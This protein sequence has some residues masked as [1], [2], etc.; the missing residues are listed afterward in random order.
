MS[1]PGTALQAD[2]DI[3]DTILENDQE[4]TLT[5]VGEAMNAEDPTS[6]QSQRK[7]ETEERDED[8][9]DNLEKG[10]RTF[11]QPAE[12]PTDRLGNSASPIYQPSTPNHFNQSSSIPDG[13]QQQLSGFGRGPIARRFPTLTNHLLPESAEL[14]R[15]E[16]ASWAQMSPLMAATLG[17]FCVLLGIPTLTQRWRGEVIDPPIDP[18]TTSHFIGLPDPPLNLALAGASLACEVL[19]N[20][21]LVLRFS[22][23][24]TKVTTWLSYGFWIAKLFLNVINYIEFGINYPQ[25]DKIIYLAGF[26]VQEH[27]IS[28][29]FRLVYVALALQSF[30]LPS[31]PSISLFFISKVRRVRSCSR[32]FAKVSYTASS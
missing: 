2:E 6:H 32:S 29:K 26:W 30:F 15:A 31:L 20:T 28:L 18:K 25:T 16:A 9:V 21:L 3:E 14:A 24:H 12:D 23:F 10:L 7:L 1:V 4:A 17:P 11:K 13:K 5:Q 8:E 19:G 27:I 22:N